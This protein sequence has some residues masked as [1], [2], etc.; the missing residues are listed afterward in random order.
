M[1]AN[2]AEYRATQAAAQRFELALAHINDHAAE[3][4]PLIQDAMRE[5]IEGELESLREQLAEY[6]VR[7][8]ASG[9]AGTERTTR[10]RQ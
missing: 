10:S 3:R 8:A 7:C 2:D 5:Q 6:E 9:A 4:H 1:I